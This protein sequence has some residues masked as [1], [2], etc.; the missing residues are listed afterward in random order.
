VQLLEI[1]RKTKQNNEVGGW[2]EK[3]EKLMTLLELL[4]VSLLETKLKP[5][6]F[7]LY[8]LINY[9]FFLD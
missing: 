3:E 7:S 2:K 1:V 6:I 8:K 9:C 5:F 4:N